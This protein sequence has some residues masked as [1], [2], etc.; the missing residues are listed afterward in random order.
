M[1]FI[2]FKF[3]NTF[4]KT[5]DKRVA[6]YPPEW[7]GRVLGSDLGVICEPYYK[8]LLPALLLFIVIGQF[9]P[10]KTVVT[11]VINSRVLNVVLVYICWGYLLVAM[12]G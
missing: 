10:L 4:N 9:S 11:F 8:Q 5:Y 1:Q 6:G 3:K 12:K 7:T 2:F